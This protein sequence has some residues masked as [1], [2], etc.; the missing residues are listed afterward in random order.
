MK[1]EEYFDRDFFRIKEL[2]LWRPSQQRNERLLRP[3][4][5]YLAYKVQ[6][7]IKEVYKKICELRFQGNREQRLYLRRKPRPVE[8]V[9][10]AG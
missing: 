1:Q 2:R 6:D 10:P 8:L 7:V 4:A 9:L 3:V 5:E